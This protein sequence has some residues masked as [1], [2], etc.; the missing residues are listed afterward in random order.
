MLPNY[1]AL[2]LADLNAEVK[3]FDFHLIRD[4]T[5]YIDAVLLPVLLVLVY[6]YVNAHLSGFH[7]HLVFDKGAHHDRT[8]HMLLDLIFKSRKQTQFCLVLL[9]GWLYIIGKIDHLI[10]E[11]NN[12]IENG[13]SMRRHPR[14]RVSKRGLILSVELDIRLDLFSHS[15]YYRYNKRI[16]NMNISQLALPCILVLRSAILDLKSLMISSSFAGF[17]TKYS[18]SSSLPSNSARN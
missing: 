14:M 9:R 4:A 3:Y 2:L 12:R 6:Y 5:S 15:I 7:V 8:L 16:A 1:L 13:L 18:G 10:V 17:F 11:P